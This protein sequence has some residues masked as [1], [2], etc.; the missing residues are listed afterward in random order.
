MGE[1]GA[2]ALDAAYAGITAV[3]AELDDMELLLPTGCRGWLVAD[4]LL[5]VTG[6][7]QRALVALAT[8]ADGPADVDAISYWRDFAADG[9]PTATGAHAQWVRRSAAAFQRPTGVVQVWSDTAPAAVRAA[10]L[11][12]PGALIATQGHVLTVADFLTT[13]VTEAVIHHFDLIMHLPDAPEPAP[14]AESVA[15]STMEGIAGPDGLPAHWTPREALL[16]SAGRLPLSEAERRAG[17][18]LVG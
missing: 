15:L 9:D 12:D 6:D 16:K 8:P 3:V 18:P 7:A 2:S 1:S 11:A 13:L 5:H 4:L 10:S 17:F 14:A